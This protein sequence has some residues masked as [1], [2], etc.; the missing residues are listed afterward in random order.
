[1]NGQWPRASAD[2]QR[3]HEQRIRDL[4]RGQREAVRLLAALRGQ[5]NLIRERVG[6]PPL[7]DDP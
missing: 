7:P 2:P 1:M 4:E 3:L 5:I 6:L